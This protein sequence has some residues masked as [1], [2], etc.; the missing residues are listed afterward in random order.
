[1]AFDM[2]IAEINLMFQQMENQPEDAHELLDRIHL[3]LN[4][5]KASGMPLPEDL[6]EL[7]KKLDAEFARHGKTR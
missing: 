2:I 6:V 1:M 3:E 4:Q 5:L 7:E